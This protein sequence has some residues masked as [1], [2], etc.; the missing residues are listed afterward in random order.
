MGVCPPNWQDAARIWHEDHHVSSEDY[1]L[2][3]I[4]G[5]ARELLSLVGWPAALLCVA[6]AFR[7]IGVIF[8]SEVGST[9]IAHALIN[10]LR[11]SSA[12]DRRYACSALS[13]TM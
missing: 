8:A 9:Y 7:R 6:H 1:P 4:D 11:F 3:I 2:S 5:I 13:P 12:S 10:F